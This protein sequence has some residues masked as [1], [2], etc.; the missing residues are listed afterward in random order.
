MYLSRLVLDARSR[1]ARA[2]LGDAHQ[3]H[4][5]IMSGFPHAEGDAARAALGVLFRVERMTDPPAIPVL[6]QSRLEPRWTLESDA[7]AHIEAARPLDA[8]LAAVV[9]GH[10]YRFRLRANPTRRVHV[11]ASEAGGTYD[12]RRHAEKAESVGKRVELTREEDQLGWLRRHGAT[13]GFELV[14][15][16]LEPAGRAV[17]SVAASP[18]VRMEGRRQGKVMTLATVLFEG[19]LEVWDPNRFR[20]ALAVGI[21]PGKAFGCGLLSV[22]PVR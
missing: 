21:G 15:V 8:L 16:R 9:A 7:I 5:A 22:A 3:L 11:R 10:R 13:S 1:D 14:T 4:R 12:G 2:W 18:V 17:E 19:M 6:V 20:E